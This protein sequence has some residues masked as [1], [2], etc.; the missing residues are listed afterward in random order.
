[1]AQVSKYPISKDVADRIFDV[2]IKSLIKVK[3]VL[4]AQNLAN[5]LFSPTEKV[6]L[7]KRLVI[8][9]LLMKEYEYREISK[10]LRVSLGTIA[11]VNLSLK[12]GSDGYKTILD[13]ISKEESLEDFFSNTAEKLLS[14]PAS[15]GKGSGVWRSLRDEV[16]K[17]KNKKLHRQF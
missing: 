12:H 10:L 17:S 4:D 14:I 3:N 8:A 9:F 11:S 13:R 6:M 1:M 16:K 2:F 5:D 7:A 15:G